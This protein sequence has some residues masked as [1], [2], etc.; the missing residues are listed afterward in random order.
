M[1]ANGLEPRRMLDATDRARQLGSWLVEE[2]GPA[3][4]GRQQTQQQL[5]G[6]VEEAVLPDGPLADPAGQAFAAELLAM[7]AGTQPPIPAE[8]DRPGPRRRRAVI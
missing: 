1:I 3:L 8:S 2:L 6:A 7:L 4:R 5:R